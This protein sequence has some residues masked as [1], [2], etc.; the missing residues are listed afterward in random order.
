[1]KTILL[2]LMLVCSLFMTSGCSST[3]PVNGVTP[4]QHQ[5]TGTE[6]G[7][8]GNLKNDIAG[9]NKAGAKGDKAALSAAGTVET[10]ADL[11]WLLI[12]GVVIIAVGGLITWEFGIS[13]GGGAFVLGGSL[14]AASMLI[15]FLLPYTWIMAL[16]ILGIGLIYVAWRLRAY[17]LCSKAKAMLA[18][19]TSQVE[20]TAKTVVADVQA[21]IKK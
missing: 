2:G 1:M 7:L 6:A 21:D 15:T 3:R 19:T 14:V 5:V 13:L 8:L 9:G 17:W 10:N 16:S 4:T 11:R 20:S 12:A 18:K